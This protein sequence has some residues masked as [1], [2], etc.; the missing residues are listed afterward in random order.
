MIFRQYLHYSELLLTTFSSLFELFGINF[1]NI[2]IKY[3]FQMCHKRLWQIEGFQVK[4]NNVL[5]W[6]LT[7]EHCN[8]ASSRCFMW[9]M[10]L[11]VWY[12]LVRCDLNI[13]VTLWTLYRQYEECQVSLSIDSQNTQ[14][15]F[16][17]SVSVWCSEDLC[18]VGDYVLQSCYQSSYADERPPVPLQIIEPWPISLSLWCLS[19]HR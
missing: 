6:D 7:F 9:K 15:G 3:F 4:R 19:P 18:S 10:S 5:K 1:P 16:S 12:V 8:R 13:C 11:K 2:F 14:T 17:V